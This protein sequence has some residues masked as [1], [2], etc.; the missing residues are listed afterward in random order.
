MSLRNAFIQA[1]FEF[2]NQL[3]KVKNIYSVIVS[4]KPVDSKDMTYTP[5][6]LTDRFNMLYHFTDCQIISV[7]KICFNMSREKE[8]KDFPQNSRRVK[9]LVIMN[10]GNFLALDLY[11]RIYIQELR[12]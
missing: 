12:F 3:N 1:P 6:T 5:I 2:S 8:I 11:K 4:I 10:M 9:N 7:R